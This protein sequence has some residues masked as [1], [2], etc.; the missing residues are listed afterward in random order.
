MGWGT[1]VLSDVSEGG[2]VCLVGRLCLKVDWG[3]V[4]TVECKWGG[5]GVSGCWGSG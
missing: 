5:V 1:G 3:R 4:L 2:V